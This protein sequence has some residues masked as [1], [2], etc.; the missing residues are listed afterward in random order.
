LK[1]EGL[2]AV[3]KMDRRGQKRACVLNVFYERKV[4]KK[5]RE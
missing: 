4:K 5:R 3:G 1:E 2:R